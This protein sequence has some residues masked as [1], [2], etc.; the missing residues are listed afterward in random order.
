MPIIDT[1][2]L[3]LHQNRP[4]CSLCASS[5]SFTPPALSSVPHVSPPPSLRASPAF[6]L[7]LPLLPSIL[8]AQSAPNLASSTTRLR[9]RHC[10][11]AATV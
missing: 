8:F 7:P 3:S 11:S 4:L 5:S 9:R 10:K 1:K 2:R 6:L